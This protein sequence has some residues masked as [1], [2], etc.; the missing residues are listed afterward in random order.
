MWETVTDLPLDKALGPDGFTGRFYKSWWNIIKEDVLLAL[1]DIHQGHLFKFK[2]LNRTF[3][4]LLP[5]KLDALMVKDFRPISLIHSFAKLVTNILANR[6]AP[7]LPNLVP[8]NQS[9]F[10]RGRNIHDK[11]LF[12][13]QMVKAL[14]RKERPTFSLNWTSQTLLIRCLGLFCWKFFGS[15]VSDS[16]GVTSYADLVHFFYPGFGEWDPR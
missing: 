1:S 7:S 16:G 11:F 10:I 9:V 15:S 5:K 4:M 6:L 2:L 14:H 8:T 13:Q 12:V 3:I